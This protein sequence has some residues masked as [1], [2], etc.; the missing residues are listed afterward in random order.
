ML[1]CLMCFNW[2]CCFSLV[3]APLFFYFFFFFIDTATTEIYTVLTHSFPTRRSADLAPASYDYAGYTLCKPGVWSQGPVFLQQLALLKGFDIA[4][5]DP[6]GPDF[7]HTQVECAKLALADREAWYGDPAVNDVPL[8]TLL[9]DAYNDARRALVGDAASYELRPGSPDGRTPR[10]AEFAVL[11][12]R[13]RSEEH[14]SELQSLMRISY[15]VF[16]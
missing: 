12:G 7:V 4:A 6:N 13:D 14:T 11:D 15:A 8:A 3:T 5:M 2:L 9:S 16:S 1:F 10:L